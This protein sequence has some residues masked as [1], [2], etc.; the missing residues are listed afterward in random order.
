MRTIFLCCG[1]LLLS[2]CASQGR[3]CA[4]CDDPSQRIS[5]FQRLGLGRP[6]PEPSSLPV[7]VPDAYVLPGTVVPA[8][9]PQGARAT[10]GAKIQRGRTLRYASFDR[11]PQK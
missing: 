9:L 10:I 7:T 2:G 8:P 6:K 5:L 11:E 4:K 3:Q 1:L